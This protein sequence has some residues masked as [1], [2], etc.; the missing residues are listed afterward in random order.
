MLGAKCKVK[1]LWQCHWYESCTPVSLIARVSSCVIP[2]TYTPHSY[3]HSLHVVKVTALCGASGL[4]TQGA[5]LWPHLE[6]HA[7]SDEN[8][9]FEPPQA[10]E[11][12]YSGADESILQQPSPSRSPHVPRYLL[13]DPRSLVPADGSPREAAAQAF[14]MGQS[15]HPDPFS[16]SFIVPGERWPHPTPREGMLSSSCCSWECCLP[17]KKGSLLTLSLFPLLWST[18]NIYCNHCAA[19]DRGR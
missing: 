19:S 3:I 16:P 10:P 7:G 15:L 6:Y 1:R 9:S 4:L 12:T 14:P 8:L 11:H 13:S 5:Q 2:Y 18:S 17:S